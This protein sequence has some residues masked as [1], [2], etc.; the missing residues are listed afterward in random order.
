MRTQTL[1][2][3]LGVASVAAL[4]VTPLEAL[5]SPESARL[6]VERAQRAR[7]SGRLDESL[8]LLQQAIAE[9]PHPVLI[10]N[11]ARLLED[12]GR[13]RESVEAYSRVV[14]DVR[15]PPELR[16]RDLAS[17][18]E[19]GSKVTKAWMRIS[20]GESVRLDGRV[21]HPR[22]L[23]P[24]AAVQPDDEPVAPGVHAI[25]LDLE[26]GARRLTFVDAIIGRRIDVDLSALRWG[27]LR[28]PSTVLELSV[29]GFVL[30]GRLSKLLLTPGE[31]RIH[32]KLPKAELDVRLLISEAKETLLPDS[33]GTSLDLARVP[34]VEPPNTPSSVLPFIALGAAAAA[35]L[36]G[37]IFS[38][39]GAAS[40]AEADRLVGPSGFLDSESF[41]KVRALENDAGASATLGGVL[42][43]AGAAT[44]G[45]GALLLALGP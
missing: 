8:T 34:S 20:G 17:I 19:L 23:A 4:D 5:A 11:L 35:V 26:P 29:D 30:L 45:L 24:L 39:K 12:L 32:A 10:H 15:A 36:T 37:G 40:R 21:V 31:H 14:R 22:R 9:D 43:L 13:F 7:E 1:A 18:D 42:L 6:L 38:I 3:F 16:A 41:E 25:E 27:T 44:L 33:V 2:C 28:I